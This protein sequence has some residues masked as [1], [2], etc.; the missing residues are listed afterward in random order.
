MISAG[1]VKREAGRQGVA[2]DTVEKDYVLG[3][4]LWGIS[5]SRILQRKLVFRGGTAIR[6]AYF[7]NEFRYS[8]DLDFSAGIA[9]DEQTL[10]AE[11]ENACAG[12]V[13]K[14]GMQLR[15]T[16]FEKVHER[17]G[18][19]SFQARVQFNGPLQRR[20]QVLPKVRIDFDFDEII[21]F[22][23]ET[24]AVFHPYSDK[25]AVKMAT[26]S[27]QE[28]CAE[29][30]RT[31]LQRPWARHFFDAWFLLA[32][33]RNSVDA[34]QLKKAFIQKCRYK[35]VAFESVSDFFRKNLLQKH[36]RDW[37]AS[38]RHLVASLPPFDQVASEL[39]VSLREIFVDN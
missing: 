14:T 20:Q 31:V 13:E 32:K 2:L 16:D 33:H 9:I 39:Q 8:E 25:P 1:E 29:K 37:D 17:S 15:L 35:D 10:K 28:I 38:L 24:R 26:Y 6:K 18:R 34:A 23:P 22:R 27:L 30:L 7:K 19:S 5:H 11:M 21:V 4:L 36:R 12:I 3:W